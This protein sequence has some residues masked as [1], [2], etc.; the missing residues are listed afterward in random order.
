MGYYPSNYLEGLR[1]II[2]TSGW[3]AG[4]PAVIQAE[5]LQNISVEHYHHIKLLSLSNLKAYLFY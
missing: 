2:K 4:V 3:T 1:K 5:I